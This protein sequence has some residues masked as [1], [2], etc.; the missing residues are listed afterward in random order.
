M[1]LIILFSAFIL[2]ILLTPGVL[3]YIPSKKCILTASIVHG[4]IFTVLLAIIINLFPN[5]NYESF[6]N[7]YSDDSYCTCPRKISGKKYGKMK[8]DE[9]NYETRGVIK[10]N[11]KSYNQ[12]K[13]KS[14]DYCKDKDYYD[15]CGGKKCKC[16]KG[17]VKKYYKS[18][19]NQCRRDFG[20]IN[21]IESCTSP[22]KFK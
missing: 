17:S 14:G 10:V 11:G 20:G 19:Y 13:P 4:I 16:P 15:N 6:D 3:L 1:N 18:Y 5:K 2:F 7:K 12:F 8:I 22:I 21:G 9:S